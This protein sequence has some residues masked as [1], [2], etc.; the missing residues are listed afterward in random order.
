MAKQLIV[1][2]DDCGRS[3]GVTRGIILG[4]Q[5]GIVTSTTVM[6]N[7]PWAELAMEMAAQNPRLGVGV[8]LTFTLGWPVLPPE[9]IPSLV[10][11][12]G[13]FWTQRVLREQ[14]DRIDL[15][16]LRQEFEAQIAAFRQYDRAPTHLDCHHLLHIF[17]SYFEVIADVA[18]A[19]SLPLRLPFLVGPR[20]RDVLV[21]VLAEQYHVTPAQIQ[22]MI[23]QDIALVRERGLRH[24]EHFIGEFFGRAA[25]T[26]ANLKRILDTVPEG[27][28][29]LMVHPGFP[30]HELLDSSGYVDERMVELTILVSDEIRETIRKLDIELVNFG[31]LA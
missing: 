6:M 29:E 23:Q 20:E 2:A 5:A 4:H 24:P 10:D 14:P 26:A 30:D 22:T 17:P 27:L 3:R 31:V 16:E 21:P 11:D 13:R 12:A 19:E 9:S 8:H 28:T 1:N 18:Q 15:G 25:L 7:M